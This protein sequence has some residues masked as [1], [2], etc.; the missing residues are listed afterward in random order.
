MIFG[1]PWVAVVAIVAI[2][3]AV[4]GGIWSDIRSKELK[5]EEKDL[6]ALKNLMN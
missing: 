5:L 3:V 1:L 6:L 2:V 4:G